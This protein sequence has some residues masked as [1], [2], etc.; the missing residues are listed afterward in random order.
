MRFSTSVRIVVSLA[1]AG[2]GM[3]AIL[4]AWQVPSELQVLAFTLLVFVIVT[5]LVHAHWSTS[6]LGLAIAV[7]VYAGI[8]LPVD[9][10]LDTVSGVA[11]AGGILAIAALGAWGLSRYVQTLEE[12]LQEQETL[13]EELSIYDSQSGAIRESHFRALLENEINRARRYSLTLALVMLR[14]IEAEGQRIE[15]KASFNNKYDQPIVVMLKEMTRSVDRIGQTGEYEHAWILMLPHT[16][17]D[18]AHV[19]TTRMLQRL[20][21]ELEL[22]VLAGIVTFPKDGIDSDEL[23]EEAYAALDFAYMNDIDIASRRLLG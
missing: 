7:A 8:V 19:V 10:P 4:L 11:R 13:I 18:G 21:T 12:S 5:A 20:Q 2:I 3:I 22:K 6:V 16:D 14:P 17:L 15:N 1:V 9:T 23:L